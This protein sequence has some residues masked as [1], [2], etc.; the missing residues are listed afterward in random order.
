MSWRAGSQFETATSGAATAIGALE[1]RSHLDA[2]H[3]LAELKGHEEKSGFT[4][5][6]G[7]KA[8]PRQCRRQELEAR[9]A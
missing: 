8:R 6:L 1:E 4:R 5:P 2:A 3:V 7:A 9:N